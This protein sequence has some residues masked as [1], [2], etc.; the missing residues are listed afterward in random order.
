MCARTGE[1]TGG[2]P[3]LTW[4]GLVSVLCCVV[5]CGVVLCPADRA[6]CVRAHAGLVRRQLGDALKGAG[7]CRAAAHAAESSRLICSSGSP[8]WCSLVPHSLHSFSFLP[9]RQYSASGSVKPRAKR[10]LPP[11]LPY[12]GERANSDILDSDAPRQTIVTA[13]R[14]IT[15]TASSS[16][17]S[18]AFNV[19][20]CSLIHR[21]PDTGGAVSQRWVPDCNTAAE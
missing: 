3:D 12:A 15:Y 5:S 7:A 20:L 8:R 10:F 4:P 14:D 2:A 11:V 19:R 18:A 6:G 17:L 13:V 21:K 16:T 1:G 9:L